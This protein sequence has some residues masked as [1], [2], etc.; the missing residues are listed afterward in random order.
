ME[1]LGGD[2]RG[3][4]EESQVKMRIRI[5]SEV[6]DW[7]WESNGNRMGSERVYLNHMFAHAAAYVGEDH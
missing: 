4:D 7:K 2:E 1:R 5:A 3:K 6:G